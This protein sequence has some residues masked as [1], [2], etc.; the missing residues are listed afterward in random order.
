MHPDMHD[1]GSPTAP[2]ATRGCAEVCTMAPAKAIATLEVQCRDLRPPHRS[3]AFRRAPCVAFHTAVRPERPFHG[4]SMSACRFTA[5]RPER[6]FHG[7]GSIDP[8]GP[9]FHLARILPPWQTPAARRQAT[10]NHRAMSP[11]CDKAAP[12]RARGAP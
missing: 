3:R 11:D 2:I 8:V 5:V 10:T 1:H 9:E 7:G 12:H 6:P 4:G